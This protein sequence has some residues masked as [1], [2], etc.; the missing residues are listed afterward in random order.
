MT[1]H[2]LES[3]EH[4]AKNRCRLCGVERRRGVVV[5][6][7]GSPTWKLE[8]AAIQKEPTDGNP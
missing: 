1:Q 7:D 8:W 2:G 4:G 6:P 5:G 3:C